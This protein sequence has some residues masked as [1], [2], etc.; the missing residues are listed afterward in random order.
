MIINFSV[1]VVITGP[2][3]ATVATRTFVSQVQ[4]SPTQATL[5]FSGAVTGLAYTL[6]A[7]QATIMNYQGGQN[8]AAAGTF[9]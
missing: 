4:N 6:A 8:L 3:T 9:S 7:A 5:T 2:I 1:P